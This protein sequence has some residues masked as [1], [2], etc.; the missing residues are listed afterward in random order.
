MC[1]ST[2]AQRPTERLLELAQRYRSSGVEGRSRKSRWPGARCPS[3]KRLTHGASFTA[4][5]DFVMD[6]VEESAATARKRP[7]DVDR[8][9][10]DD[11]Q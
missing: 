11:R 3:G 4:I 7:L 1:C 9:A 2:V 5:A 10:A 6:D 8:R